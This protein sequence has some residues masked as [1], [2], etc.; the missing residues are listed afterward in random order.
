MN[1]LLGIF[2]GGM[3]SVGWVILREYQLKCVPVSEQ[4]EQATDLEIL[5]VGNRVAGFF[6]HV[7]ATRN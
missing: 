4:L 2:F 3:I 1:L 5:G 6:D 7:A